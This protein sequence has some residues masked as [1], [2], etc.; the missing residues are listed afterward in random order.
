MSDVQLPLP[1][2]TLP[3]ALLRFWPR[4][5]DDRRAVTV[6]SELFGLPGVVRLEER[7]FAILPIGGRASVFDTAIQLSLAYFLRLDAEHARDEISGILIFPAEV[8]RHGEAVVLVRDALVE[9]LDRQPPSLPQR[10]DR[11]YRLCRQLAPRPFRP[12][13]AGSLLRSVR[14]KGAVLQSAGPEGAEPC[15]GTIRG[16]WAAGS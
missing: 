4:S 13:E 3:V 12:G 5:T 2:L 11:P 9:D 8:I 6:A 7:V 15:R 1:S 16:C 14:P 10:R